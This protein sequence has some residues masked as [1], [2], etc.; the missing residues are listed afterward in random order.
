MKMKGNYSTLIVQIRLLEIYRAI[1]FYKRLGFF[2]EG[3]RKKA[4]KKDGGK[5]YF[6]DIL[7]GY[8]FNENMKWIYH[9][10]ILLEI[11]IFDFIDW[12]CG[13]YKNVFSF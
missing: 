7:M 8:F 4:A 3:V 2:H 11:E 9:R 13:V 6:D 1:K 10:C 12:N 5:G